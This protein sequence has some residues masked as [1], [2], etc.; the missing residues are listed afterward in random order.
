MK[1]ER[2]ILARNLGWLW[3]HKI[4]IAAV[5][6]IVVVAVLQIRSRFLDTYF[7]S[8]TERVSSVVNSLS[9]TVGRELECIFG[10]VRDIEKQ[11]WTVVWPVFE[12]TDEC[13]CKGGEFSRSWVWPPFKEDEE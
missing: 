8:T 12:H 4:R 6:A 9:G 11:K 13:A 7:E 10:T 1:S 3:R 5:A 2:K